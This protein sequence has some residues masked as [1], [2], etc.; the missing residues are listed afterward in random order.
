MCILP[1]LVRIRDCKPV[2]YM[3]FEGKSV[4]TNWDHLI[5]SSEDSKGMFTLALTAKYKKLEFKQWIFLL[6]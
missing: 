3:Y 4:C 1:I 5:L 2:V 6:L